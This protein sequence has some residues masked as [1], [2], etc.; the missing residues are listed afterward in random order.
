L[1]ALPLFTGCLV[2]HSG[3][4]SSGPLLK[5][6]D[7]Y[8]DMA[9]G[10]AKS[11]FVFGF[12]NLEKENLVME[13]RRNMYYNRPLKKDEYYSNFSTSVTNK[14]I[15]AFIHITKVS[16]SADLMTSTNES[17]EPFSFGFSN[18]IKA[19]HP[20]AEP[21]SAPKKQ[22]E[23][24]SVRGDLRVGDS[25]Y[26]SNNSKDYRLYKVTSFDKENVMITS[27]DAERKNLLTPLDGNFFNINREA[28]GFKAGDTVTAELINIYNSTVMEDGIILGI[29]SGF[30]LVETKSGKYK[31]TETKIKHK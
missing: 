7:Q 4:V 30:F 23:V 14:F 22:A 26:Y 20:L 1:S 2:S 21:K 17:G 31:L 8:T 9:E 13:A 28:L 29:D 27:C 25:V 3:T 5:A 24:K 15:L 10:K 16:V 19:E 6:T 18:K 12:G 11:V